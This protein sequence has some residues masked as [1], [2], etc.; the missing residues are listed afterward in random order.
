[1]RMTGGELKYSVKNVPV[2]LFVHH[3]SHM[4]RPEI[5]PQPHGEGVAANRLSHGKGIQRLITLNYIYRLRSYRAV[6]TLRL[7]Y[8]NQSVNA[9]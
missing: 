8:T 1:M 7:C 3:K 9:V 5:K 2:P 6:N 4:D